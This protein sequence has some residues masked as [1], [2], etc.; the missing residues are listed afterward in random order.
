[1]AKTASRR[2]RR[3]GKRRLTGAAAAAVAASRRRRGGRRRSG[4]RA[5]PPRGTRRRRGRRHYR[6]SGRRRRRN[7][8]G[9]LG[10][11]LPG[12]AD[13]K[14]VLVG[15][16]QAAG[17]FVAVNGISYLVD[18][19][20]GLAKWKADKIAQDPTSKAPVVAN[21]LVRAGSTVLLYAVARKFLGGVAARNVAIGGGVNTAMAVVRPV[22]SVVG[23]QQGQDSQGNAVVTQTKWAQALLSGADGYEDLGA[24][25]NY[26]GV[27]GDGSDGSAGGSGVGDD[28]PAAGL[29]AVNQANEEG[30]G[31]DNPFGMN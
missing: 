24:Y 11:F 16:L 31:D 28:D 25:E 1:M 23:T 30:S 6:S 3:G 8:S 13:V 10:G 9:M 14:D 12:K 21:V 17:G 26:R 27:E 22:L 2:R 20:T 29:L 18:E 5:N 19:Y 7:P 4:R 15:G